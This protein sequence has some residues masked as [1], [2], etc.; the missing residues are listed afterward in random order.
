M[1][2]ENGDEP[3][4]SKPKVRPNKALERLIKEVGA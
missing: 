2:Q 4:Q 1:T 3:R